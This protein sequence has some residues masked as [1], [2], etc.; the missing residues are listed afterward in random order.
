MNMHRITIIVGIGED[1]HGRVIPSEKA[2]KALSSLRLYFSNRAGG[3]TETWTTGG[4][5]D[6]N[7]LITEPGRKFEMVMAVLPEEAE[8]I[9]KQM[10]QH[11]AKLLNQHTVV[12]QVE[13]VNAY[14]IGQGGAE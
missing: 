1:V 14:F 6:Q 13:P 10:A 5:Q 11:A 4:W 3:Y 2:A 9:G 8:S 7:H 12:L